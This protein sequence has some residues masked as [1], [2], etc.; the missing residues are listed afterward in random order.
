MADGALEPP[1]RHTTSTTM[2]GESYLASQSHRARVHAD[3]VALET[4]P[5]G[6][7]RIFHT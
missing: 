4:A 5:L 7:G 6:L 1:T 3:L 2:A